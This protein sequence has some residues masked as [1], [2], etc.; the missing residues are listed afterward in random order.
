VA[1]IR[2]L[3]Q[4]VTGIGREESGQATLLLALVSLTLALFL[5]FQLNSIATVTD[6]I[7][8][9]NAIDAAA[10]AE[11]DWI[12]RGMNVEAM[13]NIA[14][15]MNLAEIMMIEAVYHATVQGA[16]V[17]LCEA[18]LAYSP[19]TSGVFGQLMTTDPSAFKQWWSLVEELNWVYGDQTWDL[20]EDE[21]SNYKKLRDQLWHGFRTISSFQGAV[22]TAIPSAGAAWCHLVGGANGL[23]AAV[24]A[25]MSALPLEKGD[26]TDL[27]VTVYEGNH[28][29]YSWAPAT[30]DKIEWLFEI[31]FTALVNA[32]VPDATLSDVLWDTVVGTLM[33]P[34]G[35]VGTFLNWLAGPLGEYGSVGMDALLGEI[36][37]INLNEEVTELVTNVDW[38]ERISTVT[39]LPREGLDLELEVGPLWTPEQLIPVA[40]PLIQDH[41]KWLAPVLWLFAMTDVYWGYCDTSSSRHSPF[42]WL[43]ALTFVIIGFGIGSCFSPIGAAIGAAVGLIL[44]AAFLIAQVDTRTFFDIFY[45]FVDPAKFLEHVIGIPGFLANPAVE[46]ILG[47]L[48]LSGEALKNMVESALRVVMEMIGVDPAIITFLFEKHLYSPYLYQAQEGIEMATPLVLR[49]E[50]DVRFERFAMGMRHEHSVAARLAPGLFSSAGAGNSDPLL[51]GQLVTAEAEVYN[52]MLLDGIDPEYGHFLGTDEIVSTPDVEGMFVPQWRVRLRPCSVPSQNS[53]A[54]VDFSPEGYSALTGD[55]GF[56]NLQWFDEAG[57]R[58]TEAPADALEFMLAH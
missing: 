40:W 56:Q 58:L 28:G 17:V 50:Q 4:H 14:M 55:I 31:A 20:G 45:E 13:G 57:Q 48:G 32:L 33:S 34:L 24:V 46:G 54:L 16:Q 3:Y 29:G 6:R 7:E 2:Q 12:A 8:A 10:I 15:A 38:A 37:S 5:V 44:G 36:G 52:A 25:P 1:V 42:R 11:A 35:A 49:S 47:W 30:L 19:I 23:A 22:Q 51:S 9:Q 21:G 43:T 27:C 26:V 18:I 53:A 41:Y 39:G